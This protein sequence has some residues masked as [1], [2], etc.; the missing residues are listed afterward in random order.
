MTPTVGLIFLITS[1]PARMKSSIVR[2]AE[3][4][5][6]VACAVVMGPGLDS[7]MLVCFSMA[8]SASS[9]V[10]PMCVIMP[11]KFPLRNVSV[12]SIIM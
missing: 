3:I 2:D 10:L 4:S 7:I 5:V 6:S 1:F 11:W 12:F 8:R 9:R